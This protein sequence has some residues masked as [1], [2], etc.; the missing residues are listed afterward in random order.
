MKPVYAFLAVVQM[1]TLQHSVSASYIPGQGGQGGGIQ[2]MQA[3]SGDNAYFQQPSGSYNGDSSGNYDGY[4]QDMEAGG[5]SQGYGSMGGYQ[6]QQPQNYNNDQAAA[7]KPSM[8]GGL[9]KTVGGFVSKQMNSRSQAG[10]MNG[11]MSGMNVM[12]GMDG[13]DMPGNQGYPGQM[14][15][16]GGAAGGGMMSKLTNM[17]KSAYGKYKDGQTARR[18]A[19]SQGLPVTQQ[20]GQGGYPGPSFGS[21]SYY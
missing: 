17:A 1:L 2:S 11:Q 7:H 3:F 12:P 10:G 4:G 21:P 6:S 14:P 13:Y 19:S 20:G 9:M 5:Y 15:Q 18:Y 8:I 16:Q